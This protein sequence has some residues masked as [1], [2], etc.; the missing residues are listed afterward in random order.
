M[1]VDELEIVCGNCTCITYLS[2]VLAY[3]LVRE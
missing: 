1:L 3:K 2:I